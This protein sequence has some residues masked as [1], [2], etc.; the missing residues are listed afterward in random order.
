MSSGRT[1]AQ[2]AQCRYL[3]EQLKPA[4]DSARKSGFVSDS[5]YD[6]E[7][8]SEFDYNPLKK[9]RRI[10]KEEKKTVANLVA[11]SSTNTV[12]K[13]TVL[14]HVHTNLPDGTSVDRTELITH[15][16]S[17]S[18]KIV[19]KLFS[20]LKNHDSDID[21]EFYIMTSFVDG[22]LETQ[23]LNEQE[24]LEIKKWKQAILDVKNFP[25]AETGGFTH[26]YSKQIPHVLA[27]CVR[28]EILARKVQKKCDDIL[29]IIN[30]QKDKFTEEMNIRDAS[31]NFE[32]EN[33]YSSSY[34]R[35]EDIGRNTSENTTHF[36][37]TREVHQ[38]H[39]DASLGQHHLYNRDRNDDDGTT[40]DWSTT[41][42]ES[43]LSQGY[44]TGNRYESSSSYQPRSSDLSVSYSSSVPVSRRMNLIDRYNSNVAESI[45]FHGIP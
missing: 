12:E 45:N 20:K 5:D 22:L 38:M 1:P 26:S 23:G 10:I 34:V 14:K 18:S 15:E 43:Q 44:P 4:R 42:N 31:K 19:K 7:S 41:N 36:N 29:K 13:D 9:T 24:I 3:Q 16:E 8:D 37:S 6:S 11:G 27:L 35:F 21:R 40:Y 25:K 32:E 39:A 17:D 30:A 2:L 33:K 28:P